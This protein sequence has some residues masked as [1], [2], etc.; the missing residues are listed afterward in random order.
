MERHAWEHLNLKQ[1]PILK[2]NIF[3]KSGS[4]AY[5]RGIQI[6]YRDGESDTVNSTDGNLSGTIEFEEFDEL[7]GLTLNVTSE[8]DKRPRRFGL[9]LMRNANSNSVSYVEPVIEE[10]QAE[11]VKA[12]PNVVQPIPQQVPQGF[13]Y[14]VHR[15]KPEGNNFHFPQTW[16]TIESL[17]G[18]TDA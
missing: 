1:K 17:Q 16:P 11:E 2:M 6:I 14:R 4:E 7:V 3:K 9:T 13:T 10:P 15:T 8:S 18:R 12:A 5:M